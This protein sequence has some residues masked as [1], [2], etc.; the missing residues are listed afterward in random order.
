MRLGQYKLGYYFYFGCIGFVF[1]GYA[2]KL[3]FGVMFKQKLCH[4][5]RPSL[6][7]LRLSSSVL[8]MLRPC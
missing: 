1:E 8:T 6:A 7:L 2:E 4:H 5:P 3:N